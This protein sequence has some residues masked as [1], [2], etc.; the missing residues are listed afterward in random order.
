MFIKKILFNEYKVLEN[1]SIDFEQTQKHRIFPI[2]SI[3]GGGKSTLLQLIFTFLHCSF[4]ENRHKYL[5]TLLKHINLK[6]NNDL[7]SIIKFELEH[8]NKNIELEFF[9]KKRNEELT[10]N[11]VVI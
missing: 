1:I 8:N 5:K 4:N 10:F 9:Y 6:E 7:N 11:S 3:N 2:I